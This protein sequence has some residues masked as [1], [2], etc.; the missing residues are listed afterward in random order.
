[1]NMPTIYDND[2]NYLLDA[3]RNLMKEG[4]RS[5]ICVGYFRLRG[6][7]QLMD[8]VDR[9]AGTDESCCRLL[10][11][12]ERPPQEAMRELQR[13]SQSHPGLDGTIIR[14]ARSQIVQHFKEQIEFGLP[15]A[16]AEETLR[17]LAKQIREKK[18][19]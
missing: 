3:L 16:R 1:M 13:A 4:E 2:E 18:S 10:I 15:T 12:M 5:D 7:E 17:R 11:G 8:V 6:W 14:E 19:V 9:F